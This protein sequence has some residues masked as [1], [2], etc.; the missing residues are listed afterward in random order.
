MI[1][2]L[3]TPAPQH[4]PSLTRLVDRAVELGADRPTDAV[5][6]GPRRQRWEEAARCLVFA[7][8]GISAAEHGE[9]VDECDRL[10]GPT[11]E[12]IADRIDAVLG[13]AFVAGLAHWFVWTSW[14]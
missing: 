9:L 6:R 13:A 7:P 4:R 8:I 10:A 2:Q 12:R 1:T 5:L 14:S 11:V 3:T